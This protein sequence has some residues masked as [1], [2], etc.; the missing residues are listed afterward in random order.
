VRSVR[1]LLQ[2]K[3]HGI[4]VAA[5]LCLMKSRPTAV[6]LIR[7]SGQRQ[8]GIVR[9]KASDSFDLSVRARP[10]G[11]HHVLRLPLRHFGL[12]RTPAGKAW[13]RATLNSAVASF[14]FGSD[15]RSSCHR[16]FAS[17]LRYS[18]DA[19]GQL[20]VRIDPFLPF[21]PGVRVHG[22]EVRASD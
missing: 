15:C 4:E 20:G 14:A 18:R 10:E 11:L 17:F 16:S 7:V 19:L 3:A 21:L 5:L 1:T 2:Q 8:A 22:L 6:G 12:Q 13:S 9:E